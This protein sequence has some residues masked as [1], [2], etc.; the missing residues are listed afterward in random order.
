MKFKQPPLIVVIGGG[1]G[2]YTVLTG[3]REFV[4]RLA[5]VVS[6]ADSG[7]S[8]RVLRDE[9]GILPTSDLRQCMVALASTRGNREVL[10]KLFTYRFHQGEG[11]AGMTFGNLFMAALTDI[12]QDQ[13][14]AI[15]VTCEV[16]GIKDLVLPVTLDDVQLV[17]RYE[18]GSVVVGEHEIDEPKHRR[19][20]RIEILSTRPVAVISAPVKKVLAA[21][22]LI[23]IGPGDLYTSLICNLVVKGMVPAIKSSRAKKIYVMNLMTKWGQTS[24]FTAR[25]HLQEVENY[26]GQGVIDGVII[27][28]DW[29]LSPEILARYR[30]EKSVPVEDNLSKA[31]APRLVR[32]KVISA[33]EVERG[34]GDR[35]WRSIVRH[36]AHRL[37]R[38]ILSFLPKEKL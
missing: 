36:D 18:D 8:N 30:S 26:L 7:G 21:A 17:A 1:T 23:V 33:V 3:L 4:C 13:A 10:R 19:L 11:I 9:F 25:D 6:M 27:N 22:D 15:R 34:K 37:A 32:T 12:Y 2:T 5:A 31:D 28:N 35:L 14:K 38:A 24:G 29:R 16:L 20:L